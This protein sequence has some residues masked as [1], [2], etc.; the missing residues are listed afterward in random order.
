MDT[1]ATS[2]EVKGE[3]RDEAVDFKNDLIPMFTK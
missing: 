1:P 2:T 3:T